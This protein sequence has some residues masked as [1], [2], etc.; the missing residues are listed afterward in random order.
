[1]TAG[2]YE[3][4][5]AGSSDVYRLWAP[6]TA[7]PAAQDGVLLV[8]DEQ[9][10]L[11]Q[12]NPQSRAWVRWPILG[13]SVA[14][15]RRP[16]RFRWPSR[17]DTTVAKATP[18]RRLNPRMR[19]S[20]R[21][22]FREGGAVLFLA[23]AKQRTGLQVDRSS[24][25]IPPTSPDPPACESTDCSFFSR[26]FSLLSHPVYGS[27]GKQFCARWFSQ[28]HFRHDIL[29]QVGPCPP[30]S[31]LAVLLAGNVG[32][33]RGSMY[34]ARSLPPE[35]VASRSSSLQNVDLSRLARSVGNSEVLYPGDVVEITIATGADAGR[36]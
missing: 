6:R 30:P 22:T 3:L 17:A 23:I 10:V 14:S 4:Q 26:W 13:S 19:I 31:V 32:C 16:S 34:Q 33:R 28:W 2:V 18:T 9:V 36:R 29:D 21:P 12:N 35:L 24:Q 15:W 5:T 11:G 20:I 25:A 7:P 1:M 27:W 8:A